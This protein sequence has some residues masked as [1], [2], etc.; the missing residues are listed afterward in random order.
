M[1]DSDPHGSGGAPPAENRGRTPFT[2][3]QEEAMRGMMHGLAAGRPR[4]APRQA[5]ASNG[6]D[7]SHDTGG[8][9]GKKKSAPKSR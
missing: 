2:T 4:L 6:R 9:G 5:A 8:E 7:R 3:D 1:S